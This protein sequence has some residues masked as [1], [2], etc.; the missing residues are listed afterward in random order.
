MHATAASSSRE[1]CNVRWHMAMLKNS[2]LAQHC[3]AH[4]REGNEAARCLKA[5][6]QPCGLC[7]ASKTG[8]VFTH[9]YCVHLRTSVHTHATF[10]KNEW[11]IVVRIE[12]RE[13]LTYSMSMS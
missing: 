3:R 10:A 1:R 6:S 13:C 9:V 7:C 5:T 2:C 11:P 12:C 8:E 4:K